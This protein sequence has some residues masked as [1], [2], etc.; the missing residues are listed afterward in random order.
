MLPFERP[1]SE[2]PEYLG[3]FQAVGP[4]QESSLKTKQDKTVLETGTLLDEVN[5]A[6]QNVLIFQSQLNE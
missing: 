2:M 6:I 4:G 1:N 5:Y 3:T